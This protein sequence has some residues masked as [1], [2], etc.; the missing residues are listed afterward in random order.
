MTP[1]RPHHHRRHSHRPGGITTLGCPAK[2]V[3]PPTTTVA[4]TA[5]ATPHS[6]PPRRP[7]AG[8]AATAQTLVGDIRTARADLAPPNRASG[9]LHGQAGVAG[10]A[11]SMAGDD[12]A[13]LV[14]MLSDMTPEERAR[15]PDAVDGRHRERKAPVEQ[16]FVPLPTRGSASSGLDIHVRQA[17]EGAP[18][19]QVPRN[20]DR[21]PT[22]RP[23]HGTERPP[24]A[25]SF[26]TRLSAPVT[27]RRSGRWTRGW[28]NQ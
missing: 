17:P 28:G 11:V 5:A 15:V 24:I 16:H 14:Q 12:L 20:A 3:S 27:L 21:V 6:M 25:E 1:G 19:P 2:L 8:A 18:S 22:G 9:Y 10:G 23:R 4:A 7:S 26:T 13:V